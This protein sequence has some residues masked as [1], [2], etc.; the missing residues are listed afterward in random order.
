MLRG[1]QTTKKIQKEQDGVDVIQKIGN[2]Y[3]EKHVCVGCWSDNHSC[4]CNHDK[5]IQKMFLRSILHKIQELSD[6]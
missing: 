2:E 6:E 3:I 4:T 1:R 5:A